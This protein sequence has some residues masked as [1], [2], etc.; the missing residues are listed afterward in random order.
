VRTTRASRLTG[1]RPLLRLRTGGARPDARRGH[2]T[3]TSSFRGHA[4]KIRLP[5]DSSVVVKVI[6]M[7]GL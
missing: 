3:H 7:N 6:A 5:A 2:R 4:P 1:R